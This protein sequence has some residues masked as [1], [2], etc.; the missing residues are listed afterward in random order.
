MEAKARV[1]TM[2]AMH[3]NCIG[4]AVLAVSLMCAS[5]AATAQYL[6]NV[7]L[8]G[9]AY[10]VDSSGKMVTNAITEK[11]ILKDLAAAVGLT[12]FSNWALV[13]HIGGSSF[14]DTIDVV[15]ATSGATLDTVFGF[16]F[17]D[18]LG[19][20]AMTNTTQTE[21]RRVDYIYTKQ[22]QFAL[23]SA[24][25]TKR[26]TPD[27]SGNVR[28]STDAEMHWLVRPQGGKPTQTCSAIFTTTTPFK[29][30]P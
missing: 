7:T 26:F 2:V 15:N 19:R 13:Y 22:S 4:K 30:R 10:D 11:T 6:F 18:S 1:G 12:D 20:Y 21:V 29:P 5:P 27:G 25:L 28:T 8:R 23:G 17:G 16:Y 24:F 9:T 14:G 3:P